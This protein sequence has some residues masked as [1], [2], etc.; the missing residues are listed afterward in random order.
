MSKTKEKVIERSAVETLEPPMG[1]VIMWNDDFTPMDFVVGVLVSIFKK[2][3][4][5]ANRIMLDVH[6]K[7]KGLAGVYPYEIA[8]TKANQAI[9]RA[10]QRGLPFRMT[11]EKE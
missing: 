5:E 10:K 8:E 6:R 2:N 3:T 9:V 11:V 1:R 4:E 7:G